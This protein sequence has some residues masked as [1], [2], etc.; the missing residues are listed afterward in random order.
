M[1]EKARN[2][3]VGLTALVGIAMLAGMILIFTGLP[4]FFTRGYEVKVVFGHTHGV[5]E[6]DPVYL[7]GMRVGTI[8]SVEFTDQRDPAKGIT[9]HAVI[10][11][12]INLPGDVYLALYTK[13]FVG[14][15]YLSFETGGTP[16]INPDTGRP[17][18]YLPKDRVVVIQGVHQGSDLIPE[19]LRE[20]LSGFAKLGEDMKPAMESLRQLADS[21]NAVIAPPAPEQQTRPST[22]AP[23][24]PGGLRGTLAKIDRMLDALLAVFGSQE[25]QANLKKSLEELARAAESAR[26]AMAAVKAFAADAQKTVKDASQVVDRSGRRFDELA[27]KLIRD[28]E[29]ISTV[30]AAVS[31]VLAKIES[32]KGT[33][34][35][36]VNDPKLYQNLIEATGQ[37]VKLLE[38][39]RVLLK[40]W[41][42]GGVPIKLK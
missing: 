1:S 26:E 18:E 30:M 38:D 24:R 31:N 6:G 15:P 27:E 28:A 34:G 19:E 7:V 10:D 8:T 39:F 25:N 17:H 23:A 9:F 33:A 40:A 14:T 2:V 42:Q 22:T 16:I 35:Q 12:D 3:A 41:N 20:G 29:Q 21:L 11:R 32:G 13:G 36:L 5:H 37:M 4:G